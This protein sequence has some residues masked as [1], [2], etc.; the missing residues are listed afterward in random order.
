MK[1]EKLLGKVRNNIRNV[2]QNDFETLARYYGRIEEGSKHPKIIIKNHPPLI[3]RRE[4]R[5]KACYV[6]ELLGIIE[7]L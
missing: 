5:I 6:K 3:Y 4:T 2:S 7:S 1:K